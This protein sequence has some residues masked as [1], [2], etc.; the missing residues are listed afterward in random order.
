MKAAVREADGSSFMNWYPH[1]LRCVY[2]LAK[3]KL[4]YHMLPALSH[5]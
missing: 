3:H 4:P 2:F 1:A 5:L